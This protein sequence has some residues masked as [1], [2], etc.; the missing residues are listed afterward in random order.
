MDVVLVGNGGHA[1]ACLD[2][3]PDGPLVAIGY[4][5]PEPGER[6]GLPYLGPDDELDALAGSGLRHAFVALGSGAVRAR[7]GLR[8][9]AAGMELVTVVAPTAQIGRTATLGDGTI[10]M[11]RSVV[12]A[13][14]VIGRGCI[15]NTGAT[16]DHDV[17]VGDHV[18]IA[19]GVN[20]AGSVTIREHAMLGVGASVVPG[21]T[22][23]AG[24][25]V[26]AGAVV[27]RDVADG[28]TVVGV[29]AREMKKQ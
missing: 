7:V 17:V 27:I 26:G 24:A 6:L 1:R 4:L 21:I 16:V 9:V 14:A 28:A 23:G 5:G 20:V 22:I 10:A 8:C 12:G 13:S 29:P 25:T 3:W 15:V 11:H 19:P 2:A 18:H